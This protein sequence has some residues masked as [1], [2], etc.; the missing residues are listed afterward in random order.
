M[1]LVLRLVIRFM[2][3]GLTSAI[4]YLG[5]PTSTPITVH[6]NLPQ[7]ELD[8]LFEKQITPEDDF[9]TPEYQN[10]E[11]VAEVKPESKKETTK[12]V[13]T[14]E[15]TEKQPTPPSN[16]KAP[17]YRAEPKPIIKEIPN[18]SVEDAVVNILC[19]KK[20][21]NATISTTGTGV[22]VSENGT[23]LTN[24]H[25][26]I[27]ILKSEILNDRECTIR[28][29]ISGGSNF[30][31]SL[32]YIPSTWIKSNSDFINGNHVKSTGAN[33]FALIKAETNTKLPFITLSNKSLKK[34]DSVVTVGY[35]AGNLP[36]FS[37][38]T[39]LYQVRDTVVITAT[40]SF[41]ETNTDII[42]TSASETGY[43]GS[44]GGAVA[45]TNGE[46]SALIVSVNG[47]SI[48]AL[49]IP[50]LK[51]IFNKET[52]LNL[53]TYI[54]DPIKYKNNFK[55][56]YSTARELLRDILN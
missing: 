13:E 10:V 43:E 47:K 37:P 41:G 27:E 11:I 54:E 3:I 32:L 46:L 25:V 45:N 19:T 30:R 4:T 2:A 48:N 9:N 12:E 14:K 50:Y 21:G 34:N 5:S 29:S 36:N 53:E 24:A 23:I 39:K 52:N 55:E 22:L 8:F 49:T 56:S 33:D 35:P 38:F 40:Y 31:V 7:E 6:E 26:A 18:N 17:D 16:S 20:V 15:K 28:T 1:G 42:S 51:S 44:S